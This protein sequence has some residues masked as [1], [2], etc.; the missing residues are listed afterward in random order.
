M[1]K[2]IQTINLCFISHYNS[3]V[4]VN[5]DMFIHSPMDGLLDNF[6]VESVNSYKGLNTNLLK[7]CAQ[8]FVD[9]YAFISFG[10]IPRGGMAGLYESLFFFNIW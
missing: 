6:R 10:L 3:T 9:L 5:A 7:T 2:H 4:W 8:V 1:S